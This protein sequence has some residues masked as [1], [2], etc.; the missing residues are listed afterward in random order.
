MHTISA[1]IRNVL[2]FFF[3]VLTIQLIRK[4]GSI[5]LSFEDRRSMND[6]H[7]NIHYT[8]SIICQFER[9]IFGVSKQ[10]VQSKP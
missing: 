7:H 5:S 8:K 9:P 2:G 10:S 3:F 1:K 4:K 6:I